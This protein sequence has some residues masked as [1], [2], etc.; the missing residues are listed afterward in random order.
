MAERLWLEN[1]PVR[2]NL[3]YPKI[4]LYEHIKQTTAESGD[5]IALVFM[6]NEITY[7][8]MQENIDR[9]A[10]AL[11]DL[12]VKKGDRVALMLPNCPEYVYTYYACMKLGAIV[13]QMNP[14]Y[15]PDEVEFIIKDS[16][17]KYF[18]GVDAAIESFQQARKKVDLEQVIIVRL[19]WTEVEGE[20]LWYDELL[21]NYPPESP[22]AEIDPQE[23][24]AVFQYTGGTT[25]LP[26][27]CML[28]HY[29]LV[30]NVTQI[31]EWLK[32]WVDKVFAEKGRQHFGIGILPLF[33]SYGMT[34][35]M[36]TGLSLPSA[37]VLIPQFNADALLQAIV[38]YRPALFPAVPTIYIAV[39]NHPQLADYQI[40]GIV[41]ICNSG[42]APMPVDVMARFE[43]DTGSKM[44]EGYGLSEASPVTHCNPLFGVRKPGSVG[45]PYPDTD[46]KI[47]DL[48]DGVTEMPVG[49]EGELLI[50]GPQVM[51]GYWNR[52]EETAETLR[53][54]WLYT[55]D[56]AKM[57]EEGYFYIVDRKKDLVITGGYNVYP[58]EV[59]E[60]LFEHPKIAEA[61][62]AGIPDDYYGE[63]LKAY[64]V[65][66]EGE[67]AT[68]EEIIE[69]C[70][71][72]LARYKLPR[73]VEFRSELPKSAIGKILRRELVKKEQQKKQ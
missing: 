40:H 47:V 50:K 29:N 69:F 65:L 33:H 36:N 67:E 17:A 28:T 32:E 62:T 18:V 12:G 49:E 70:S 19:F 35:V 14:L 1:Y 25:G 57:D 22:E 8:K 72:K 20:N 15:M 26:R 55:G 48:V 21:Q 52:P 53:D 51:K 58:R 71:Q 45:L 27:A 64:V 3:E 7:R 61:V 59:D 16:G 13:V 46:C 23:D 6:G 11:T 43:R 60:V 9:I 39:A 30:A 37:Q 66:K 54:G 5:L 44:L 73:Q 38:Q 56:I 2:W 4:S 68:A 41:E 31:K 10:A 42:A 34:C 24:V 63:V